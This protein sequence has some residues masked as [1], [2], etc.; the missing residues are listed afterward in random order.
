[1]RK[2]KLRVRLSFNLPVSLITINCSTCSDPSTAISRFQVIPILPSLALEV[3]ISF[4]APGPLHE[5]YTNTSIFCHDW[6]TTAL[7]QTAA[8]L[9]RSSHRI[10]PACSM[11]QDPVFT[12]TPGSRHPVLQGSSRVIKQQSTNC[13]P[14]DVGQ[15]GHRAWQSLTISF[16]ASHTR[17]ALASWDWPAMQ[18]WE[19]WAGTVSILPKAMGLG[20]KESQ[21]GH[22]HNT[23]ETW[24]MGVQSSH[25]HL[26]VPAP[27]EALMRSRPSS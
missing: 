10:Q 26:R 23:H 5:K 17:L 1:M 13:N 21:P 8:D 25:V 12:S 4:C 6:S 27:H 18:P 14:P 24:H 11:L 16:L 20:P 2:S 9:G 22:S 7:Y 19:A 15:K 3:C